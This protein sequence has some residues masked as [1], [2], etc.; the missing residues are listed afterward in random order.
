MCQMSNKIKRKFYPGEKWL[1]VKIYASSIQ[2]ETLLTSIIPKITT[3][4]DRKS[5]IQKWFF[6]RYVDPDNH[7]RIRFLLNNTEDIT[8]IMTLLLKELKK[9]LSCGNVHKIQYDTYIREIE[10]YNEDNIEDTESLFYMDSI[11]TLKLLRIIKEFKLKDEDRVAIACKSI[12]QFLTDFGYGIEKR[13]SLITEMSD[14]LCWEFDFS[15]KDKIQLNTL[16]RSLSK[17]IEPFI[18]SDGAMLTSF[19]LSILKIISSR[20]KRQMN[21]I[22]SIKNNLKHKEQEEHKLIPSYVHMMMI[23]LFCSQ[24]RKH[25]LLVYYFLKKEYTSIIARHNQKQK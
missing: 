10:R 4:L 12:D 18:Y 23:R 7:L 1:Y 16:F 15:D 25:E 8:I 22:F 20:S 11:T 5:I 9:E 14:C 2:C 6:I 13:L 17:R 24:N 3:S 21:V 19:H